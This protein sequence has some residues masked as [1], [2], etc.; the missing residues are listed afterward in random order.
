MK[1]IFLYLDRKDT[2]SERI[3]GQRLWF[4]IQIGLPLMCSYL[5]ILGKRMV[6]EESGWTFLNGSRDFMFM[7]EKQHADSCMC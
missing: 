2:G 1:E 3:S 6:V 7:N 4:V 5:D